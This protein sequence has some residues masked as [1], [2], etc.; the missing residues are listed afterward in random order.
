MTEP[1]YGYPKG[2]ADYQKV[3]PNT[4]LNSQLFLDE[5]ESIESK[6]FSLIS[7]TSTFH[8]P[9]SRYIIKDPSTHVLEEMSASPLEL[10][11]LQM[12]VRISGARRVL[13]I[14]TFLGVSAMYFAE[15][16]PPEGRVVTIEKFDQFGA[17]AEE[18]IRVNGFGD[19]ITVVVGDALEVLDE[20]LSSDVFDF[21]FIDGNKENYAQY[22]L[23]I[24]DLMPVGGI[25]AIDDAMF[26]GDV[27]ND[28]PRTAKG[29]G[30]A[31]ALTAGSRLQNWDRVLLP[32]YNGL[33]ILRRSS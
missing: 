27:A 32:I 7:Q 1:Q 25:I 3:L 20:V 16:L 23:R 12:L 13:E 9:R 18:N 4:L 14:G 10:G 2:T 22:L 31:E 24:A 28:S 29:R 5:G 33:F 21:A 19:R 15:A 8:S 11:F 26:F 30:V 17:V 6:I